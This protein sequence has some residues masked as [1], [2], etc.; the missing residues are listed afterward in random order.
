MSLL[1]VSKGGAG[2]NKNL[3][4]LVV[5]L[6]W[7][8]LKTQSELVSQP[9]EEN[10]LFNQMLSVTETKKPGQI[11]KK[12][13]TVSL[14]NIIT[15]QQLLDDK[16]LYNLTTSYWSLAAD[17]WSSCSTALTTAHI[18]FILYTCGDFSLC[19]KCFPHR[20]SWLT[21]TPE[22]S[23]EFWKKLQGKRNVSLSTWL[24]LSPTQLGE[25]ILTVN[26]VL[27]YSK[28]DDTHSLNFFF[29]F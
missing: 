1:L 4:F 22:S 23:S 3:K 5:T 15:H 17:F 21:R 20:K 10:N 19:W 11:Y 7:H 27:F 6:I 14:V 13:S 16:Q 25:W 2:I 24:N 29:S 26:C 28:G 18:Q 8:H 12:C 9:I